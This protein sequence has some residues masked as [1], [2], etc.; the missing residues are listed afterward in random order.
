MSHETLREVYETEQFAQEKLKIRRD[1]RQLDEILRNPVIYTLA[2]S[3]ANGK[4]TEQPGVWGLPIH[5]FPG[6]EFTVFYSFTDT[7]V[8]LLSL[9]RGTEKREDYY[10]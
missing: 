9:T 8:A 4:P 2:R 6:S 3:P 10:Q 1:I 7:K 5:P